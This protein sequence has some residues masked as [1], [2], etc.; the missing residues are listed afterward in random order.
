MKAYGGF[1]K[2]KLY[3]FKGDGDL[4]PAIYKSQKACKEHFEDVRPINI[5]ESIGHEYKVESVNYKHR[6]AKE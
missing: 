1:V 2:G 3:W 5:I 4:T 6:K